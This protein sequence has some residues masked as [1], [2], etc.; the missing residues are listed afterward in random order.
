M[1]QHHRPVI[2]LFV[3][4]IGLASAWPVAAQDKPKQSPP[5]AQQ[6]APSAVPQLPVPQAEKLVLL[7]RLSLLTLNDA[8]QTGNFTVLRD[9]G[10]PSF[11]QANSAARLSRIFTNLEAQR[12]DLTAVAVLTPQLSEAQIVGPE[13]RLF[14]RGHFPGLPT[15]INFDLIYEPVDGHWQLFGLSVAPAPAQT[16]AAATEGA[17]SP[18]ALP[19]KPAA[20]K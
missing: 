10:G 18:K 11:R 2:L 6:A 19:S 12:V 15:Q 20:K 17:A 13:Q 4:L 7:I 5:A 14:V 8:L 16:P 9:R 3:F 1:H